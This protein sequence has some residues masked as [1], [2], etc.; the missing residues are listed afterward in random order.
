VRPAHFARLDT[1]GKPQQVQIQFQ[2]ASRGAFT[3]LRTVTVTNVRGY[4]DLRVAFP[5]SGS[6]R[7]AW[8]Y[9]KLSDL[10]A[11]SPTASVAGDTIYSRT[12]QVTVK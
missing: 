6:V 3:T 11:S 10:P 8:A 5:A 12:V 1:A 4:I 7:L 9:P 2:R